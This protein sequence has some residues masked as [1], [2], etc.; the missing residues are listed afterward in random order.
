MV[1]ELDR[2]GFED[3]EAISS[4]ADDWTW[5]LEMPVDFLNVLLSLVYK[6]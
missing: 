3:V 1:L 6:Q 2:D 4:G 5:N